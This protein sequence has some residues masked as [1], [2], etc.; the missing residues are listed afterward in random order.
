MAND[1]LDIDITSALGGWFSDIGMYVLYAILGLFICFIFWRFYRNKE[2]F[3]W[4]VRNFRRRESGRVKESNI[5]GGYLKNKEGIPFFR[6]KLHRFKFWQRADLYTLPDAKFISEDDRIYY[7][8][9]DPFTFVQCKRTFSTRMINKKEIKLLKK[10]GNFKV[11]TT[12]Y[13]PE[14]EAEQLVKLGVAE[15]TGEEEESE[16]QDVVFEP[17]PNDIKAITVH[18]IQQV[19]S[20]LNTD[21]TKQVLIITAGIIILALTFLGA[22]YIFVSGVGG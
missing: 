12:G 17:V 20:T 21:V 18:D 19:R 2:I 7:N 6:I 16:I 22:Y 3:R 13:L 11:G 4:K 14:E 1:L 9:I 10:H 5:K 8:Q 15:L